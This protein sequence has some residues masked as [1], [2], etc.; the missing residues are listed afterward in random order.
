MAGKSYQR[1]ELLGKGG[2]SKVF[3]VQLLNSTKIYALKKVTF[4]EVDELVVKGF[5][6]EIELLR[7]L[8][9]EERVVR[10][11]NFEIL[12]GSVNM[13]CIFLVSDLLITV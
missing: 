11:V 10:L 5:K 9:E 6:G 3:K 12:E 8:S 4:D 7:S 2:S 1:L 13:V